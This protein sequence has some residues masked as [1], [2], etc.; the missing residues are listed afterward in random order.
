MQMD[1]PTRSVFS[2]LRFCVFAGDYYFFRAESLRRRGKMM[3]AL[4]KKNHFV[5]FNRNC[6]ENQGFKCLV[7]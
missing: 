2:S 7:S 3:G 5:F 6:P 4:R 1:V